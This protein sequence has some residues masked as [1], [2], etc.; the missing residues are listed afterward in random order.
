MFVLTHR[1]RPTLVREGGTT[2]TFVTDGLHSTL[3][4]AKAVA[5]DRNVDIA[6]GPERL[7]QYLREGIVDELQL[8]AVPVLLGAGLRLFEGPGVGPLDC[9]ARVQ[10]R[11]AATPRPP[12]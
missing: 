10:S 6:G 3:D 7:R 1:P 11:T 8:H 2:F 12:F 4:Q 9:P 5:G